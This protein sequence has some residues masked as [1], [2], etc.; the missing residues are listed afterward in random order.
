M[1]NLAIQNQKIRNSNY[2][3]FL[4]KGIW[5]NSPYTKERIYDDTCRILDISLKEKANNIMEETFETISIKAHI[6]NLFS[7]LLQTCKTISCI[8]FYLPDELHID[9]TYSEFFDYGEPLNQKEKDQLTANTVK[10]SKILKQLYQQRHMEDL[11][12]AKVNI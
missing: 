6:A 12:M 4:Y 3:C 5:Y 8:N 1:A 11:I 2:P 7:K 10:E 9:E